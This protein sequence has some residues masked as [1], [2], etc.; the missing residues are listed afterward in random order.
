MAPIVLGE[1]PT[2]V[3]GGNVQ[4]AISFRPFFVLGKTREHT[5]MLTADSLG[6]GP[7]TF[8]RNVFNDRNGV[9]GVIPA[10][11]AKAG[12]GYINCSFSGDDYL[13]ASQAGKYT[14]RGVC[15]QWVTTW[16]PALG[17]NDLGNST[18][19]TSTQLTNYMAAV[20]AQITNGNKLRVIPATI[21]ARA[22]ASPYSTPAAFDSNSYFTNQQAQANNSSRVTLC[23]DIRSGTIPCD[24]FLEVAAYMET[25]KD[26]GIQP[27]PPDA[28]TVTDVVTTN[29]SNVVDSATAKFNESST[30]GR[31]FILGAGASGAP[32]SGYMVYVSPTRVNVVSQ[33]GS[34]VNAGATLAG[35][36]AYVNSHDWTEDA[37]H[38]SPRGR[39]VMRDRMYAAGEHLKIKN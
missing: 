15:G 11:L 32:L 9:T 33:T 30:G 3:G 28:R 25:S 2:N 5:V 12:I 26:S 14:K 10:L 16:V 34:V 19:V 18:V 17:T 22:G 1:I 8:N 20:R 36:T 29:N 38:V 23:R 31:I 37:L 35:A 7:V 24:N 6:R 21:M 13:N 4:T 39:D 27:Y